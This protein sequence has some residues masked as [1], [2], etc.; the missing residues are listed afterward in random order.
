MSARDLPAR[1]NLENLRKQA[2]A[3]HRAFLDGDAD[4]VQRIRDHLPRAEALPDGDSSCW[5]L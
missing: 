4:A 3:L 1:A 2:K 5:D